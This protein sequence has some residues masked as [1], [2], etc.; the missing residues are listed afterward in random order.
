M[1]KKELLQFNE[2]EQ[3]YLLYPSETTRV[4]TLERTDDIIEFDSVDVKVIGDSELYRIN[5]YIDTL[6]HTTKESAMLEYEQFKESE[7]KFYE[8]TYQSLED[9][10]TTLFDLSEDSCH[11]YEWVQEGMKHS[12]LKLGI[13]LDDTKKIEGDDTL[14]Y[15]EIVPHAHEAY[16]QYVIKDPVSNN[17]FTCAYL[18]AKHDASDMQSK[19]TYAEIQAIDELLGTNYLAFRKNVQLVDQK[20]I[21]DRENEWL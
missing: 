20:A 11:D 12:L 16:R 3:F 9:I 7:I 1:T 6:V 17:L 21:L 14:Y 5:L 18:K 13:N 15:I 4:L 19:F 10:L 2:G 8:N